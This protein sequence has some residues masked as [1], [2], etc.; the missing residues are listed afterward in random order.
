MNNSLQYATIADIQTTELYFYDKDKEDSLKVFC[1]NNGISFLPSKDRLSIYKLTDNGFTEVELSNELTIKPNYLLF[2]DETLKVFEDG[3]SSEVRFVTLNNRILGVVH[4]AD[5]NKSFIYFELYK[6]LYHL[7]SNIRELLYKAGKTND[8][9]INWMYEKGIKNDYWKNRYQAHHP[10][11]EKKLAKAIKKRL[12]LPPFQTFLLSDLINTLHSFGL[13][14]KHFNKSIEAVTSIR[15]WVM[16]LKHVTSIMESEE[17]EV[18]YN[19]ETLK[20]FVKDVNQV[21]LAFDLINSA[22]LNVIP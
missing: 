18:V 15:N 14:E 5:Y 9:I 12:E 22:K 10:L 21:F 2:S 3:D 16:H 6:L 8:D 7:E 19:F 13:V 20:T 17:K 1:T 11:D 4:I